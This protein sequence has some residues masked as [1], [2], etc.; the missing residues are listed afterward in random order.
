MYHLITNNIYP[1]YLRLFRG[2]VL[3][4]SQLKQPSSFQISGS[5]TS[6]FMNFRALIKVGLINHTNYCQ[7]QN[8]HLEYLGLGF[9]LPG[10][11]KLISIYSLFQNKRVGILLEKG[12]L[13]TL[14]FFS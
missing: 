13:D 10:L 14:I 5:S 3:V 11:G 7:M 4:I 6:P 12:M 8:R 1:F 2:R 9:W